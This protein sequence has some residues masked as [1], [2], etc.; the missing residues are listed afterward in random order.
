MRREGGKEGGSQSQ[1]GLSL[2]GVVQKGHLL[3]EPVFVNEPPGSPLVC[4]D[5]EARKGG[6]AQAP[7]PTEHS[8]DCGEGERQT[9]GSTGGP[10]HGSQMG[11]K[12]SSVGRHSQLGSACPWAVAP[13]RE[14]EAFWVVLRKTAGQARS[15][16]PW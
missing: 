14:A 6:G 5:I 1:D 12:A 3:L 4:N 7:R 11:T 8:Q 16:S 2:P 10:G 9:R 13:W 15:A